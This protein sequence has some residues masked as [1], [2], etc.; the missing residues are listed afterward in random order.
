MLSLIIQ[1]ILKGDV[2][3]MKCESCGGPTRLYGL[4]VWQENSTELPRV[5][6]DDKKSHLKILNQKSSDILGAFLQV[7]CKDMKCQHMHTL[8]IEGSNTEMEYQHF[9]SPCQNKHCK[10]HRSAH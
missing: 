5:E 9:A 2:E 3:L 1:K 8:S 6:T 7:A 4:N 10:D